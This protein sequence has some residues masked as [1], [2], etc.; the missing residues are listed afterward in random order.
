MHQN[1]SHNK[2]NGTQKISPSPKSHSNN[3]MHGGARQSS[4]YDLMPTRIANEAS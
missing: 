1:V 2:T 3:M 4:V